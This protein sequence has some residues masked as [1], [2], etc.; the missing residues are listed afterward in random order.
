MGEKYSILNV[1]EATH[2][3]MPV[4]GFELLRFVSLPDFLGEDAPFMLY[5]MGKS[6]ARKMPVNNIEQ[7]CSFFQKAG[8]GELTFVKQK[9][10]EFMFTL[11]GDLVLERFSYKEE[12]HYQFEAGFIAQ[13]LSH[14]HNEEVECTEEKNRRK[15]MVTFHAGI[16]K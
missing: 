14:I 1:S 6:L 16:V 11:T 4:Y 15:K 2:S 12:V 13:Q 8:F 10:Y 5:Y 9:K 3:S 7:L